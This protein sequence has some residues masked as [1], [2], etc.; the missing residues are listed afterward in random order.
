LHRLTIRWSTAAL[1]LIVLAAGCLRVRLLSTPLERDEGEYAYAGQLLLHGIPPYQLAYNMKLP[2]T[3]FAYALG[4]ALFGQDERGI[5]ILLTVGNALTIVLLFFLARELFGS[6]AGIA[7]AAVFGVASASPA[8]LGMAAHANHFVSLF[9]VPAT[10]LLW[11]ALRNDEPSDS[12]ISGT[13]RRAGALRFLASGLLFGV[14]FLMKQQALFFLLFAIG[15][16]FC[17]RV[18]EWYEARAAVPPGRALRGL[19]I[20][21]AWLCGGMVVPFL[22]T[23]SYLYFSGVFPAFRFWVFE[24]ARQYLSVASWADGLEYLRRYLAATSASAIGIRLLAIAGLFTAVRLTRLRRQTF[25]LALFALASFAAVSVGLFYRPHYFILGLPAMALLAGA[26]ASL[27]AGTMSN[28]SSQGFAR[29]GGRVFARFACSLVIACAACAPLLYIQ[30]SGLFRLSPEQAS[31]ANYPANPFIESKIAAG[32]LHAHNAG[33]KTLAVIGSEPQLYFYSGC[34]SI[35]GYLYTYP[36]M[37][38]QSFARKM[39]DEMISEI[40]KGRPDFVVRVNYENSWAPF[41]DSDKTIFKWCDE[42]LGTNYVLAGYVG[43]L[44]SGKIAQAWKDIAPGTMPRQ[45]CLAV[46]ER[47]MEF[48]AADVSPR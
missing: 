48:V 13:T 2:G 9:I 47:K 19:A 43:R 5:H 36:L 11:R 20:E 25:F 6:A 33:G 30:R 24:Y 21:G 14:G 27:L 1:L 3:Y 35:T 23:C 29:S 12:R 18:R 10:W 26:G 44:P 38:R 31:E 37:E 28:Q 16:L 40:E 34:R 41:P 45:D 7:A 22:L 32:Y 39:R 8:V 46:Y 17:Q 4:M 15:W 42:Y